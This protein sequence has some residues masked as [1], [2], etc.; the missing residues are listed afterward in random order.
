MTDFVIY[1]KL[2]ATLMLHVELQESDSSATVEL[3][4]TSV[5]SRHRFTLIAQ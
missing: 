1:E 2:G 4:S 5:R 3:Q